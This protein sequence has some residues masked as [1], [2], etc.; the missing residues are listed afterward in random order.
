[1][2]DRLAAR[3]VT[4]AYDTHRVL[5]TVDFHLARGETQG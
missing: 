3:G 2:T 5:D 1:V 4:V